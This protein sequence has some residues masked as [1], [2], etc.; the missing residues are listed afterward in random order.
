MDLNVLSQALQGAYTDPVNYGDN[1]N[2][3]TADMT[4]IQNYGGLM[5]QGDAADRAIGA[6][7]SVADQNDASSRAAAS[8]AA[9][10]KAEEAAALEDEIARL[11]D[12]KS[13]QA[14]VNQ[15]GGYDFY[16]PV[17]NKISAVDYARATNKRVSE[18]LKD[19]E[20]ADDQDFIADYERVTE[21]GKIIQGNDKEARDKFFKKNADWAEMYKDV[22]FSEIVEDLHSAY[23]DYFRGKEG[24]RSGISGATANN[25]G[26]TRTDRNVFQRAF[27]AIKPGGR[28][29][30]ADSG[31]NPGF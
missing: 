4:N 15:A 18:V 20:A 21:L 17:G 13:Y 14:I 30:S 31:V 24:K 19:S 7:G 10:K 29:W 3:S 28:G 25:T 16:D 8:A 2:G 1:V 22:P 12:P 27:D 26:N 9:K 6:L 23:P 11:K 5:A